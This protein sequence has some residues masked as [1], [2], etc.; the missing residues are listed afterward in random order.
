MATVTNL[1]QTAVVSVEETFRSRLVRI[2]KLLGLVKVGTFVLAIIAIVGASLP[3]TPRHVLCTGL[4][5]NAAFCITRGWVEQDFSLERTVL[6]SVVGVMTG[7]AGA[8]MATGAV[9]ATATIAWAVGMT[10]RVLLEIVV[11]LFG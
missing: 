10:L 9:Y 11:V 4:L 8:D 3:E 2:L 5:A 1:Y 7:L 6:Y